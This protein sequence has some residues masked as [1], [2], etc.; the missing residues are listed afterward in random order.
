MDEI[1]RKRPVLTHFETSAI[2]IDQESQKMFF[3]DSYEKFV[4]A[5]GLDGNDPK[6]QFRLH[7]AKKSP[8]RLRSLRRKLREKYAV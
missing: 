8:P 2:E 5:A 6:V 4:W 3:S 7:Q 1:N